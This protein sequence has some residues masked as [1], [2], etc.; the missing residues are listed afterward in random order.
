LV[1]VPFAFLLAGTAVFRFTDADLAISQWFYGGP[2][3]GWPDKSDPPWGAFYHAGCYPGLIVGIG[4]LTVALASLFWSRVRAWRDPGLFLATLLV[5]GPGLLVNVTLKDHW[6]RPRP[7][8]TVHFGGEHPFHP[9]GDP[10]T[11]CDC[12]SFPSGHASMGF[13]LMAPAFLLYRKHRR[14]A[15][16]FLIL[17]LTCGIVIGV[18]RIAQG[19]HFASDVLW[20][21]GIVYFT[22]LVL[23][24][25]HHRRPTKPAARHCRTPGLLEIESGGIDT[26]NGEPELMPNRRDYPQAA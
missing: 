1:I 5:L 12:K 20:S 21:A 17:G 22:G 24:Y 15:A 14:L 2:S 10:G 4:G 18:A 23:A 25:H 26:R 6:G 19:R 7:L 13:Y 9:V 11:S 16:T 3:H 8:Q